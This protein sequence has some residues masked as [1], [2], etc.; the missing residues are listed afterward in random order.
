MNITGFKAIVGLYGVCGI[1]GE[2][3]DFLKLSAFF[4]IPMIC[5]KM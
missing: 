4:Q 5:T 1:I 3:T 2:F